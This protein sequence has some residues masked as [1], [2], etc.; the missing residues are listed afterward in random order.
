VYVEGGSTGVLLLHGFTGSPASLRPWAEYLAGQGH[1][2][3]AP[4]LPGHGTSVQE[5]NR[6]RWQDWY[7]EA[8]HALD[9]LTNRC[10]EVY[11][12]GLS[13]G[14]ALAL[15]L[16][17]ER[18]QDVAGLV[19][20]NPIVI[21]TDK[22]L[23]VTPVLKRLIGSVSG[24]TNDIKK[25]GVDECGYA[26]VPLRALDSL[27][28]L[29]TVVRGDLPR[30]T[31]PLLLFRS[32]EDHVVEPLSSELVLQRVSSRDVTE[33]VLDNSYHV[34]TLDNDA[35]GIFAESAEFI[36][37]TSRLADDDAAF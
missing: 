35:P 5:M 24:I 4:R 23:L 27:R 8:S 11:V 1:T 34:A 18:D 16:A 26:R 17:A 20:V 10:A 12:A 33:R 22:R 7:S 37:K 6:T 15:R 28:D 9:R 14:G 2:V 19:L 31:A 25:P 32:V 29:M 30:V 3:L 36:V 13:M 21:K